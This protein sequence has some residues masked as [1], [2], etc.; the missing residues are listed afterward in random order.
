[1]TAEQ[2]ARRR[3]ETDTPGINEGGRISEIALAKTGIRTRPT[4]DSNSI[5]FRAAHEYLMLGFDQ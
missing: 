1:M 5:R 3:H 4:V 2:N